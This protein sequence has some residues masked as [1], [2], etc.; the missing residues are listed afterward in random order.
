MTFSAETHPAPVVL[1]SI[2]TT[3]STE[4]LTQTVIAFAIFDGLLDAV[5]WANDGIAADEPACMWLS[6]LRWVRALDG[7]VPAGAPEPPTRW[8]DSHFTAVAGAL[9]PEQRTA[10]SEHPDTV[11]LRNPEMSIPSRPFGIRRGPEA[12]YAN[13]DAAQLALRSFVLALLPDA[14]GSLMTRLARDAAALTHGAEASYQYAQGVAAWVN[15]AFW[16]EVH[17]QNDS[18]AGDIPLELG[19]SLTQVTAALKNLRD[20]SGVVVPE[21]DATLTALHAFARELAARWVRATT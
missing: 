20:P 3:A 2:A 19:S 4:T 12:N 13:D 18:E 16:P 11:S 1:E 15:K 21:N 8:T 5:E 9:T 6:T 17:G 14:D 10:V 7:S